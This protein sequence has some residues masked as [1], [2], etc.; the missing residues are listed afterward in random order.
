MT[1]VFP[2]WRIALDAAVAF[3]ASLVLLL[4]LRRQFKISLAEAAIMA[5]TAGLSVLIWRSFA[6]TPTLNNDPIPP[7]SPN[8]TLSPV[9]AYVALGMTAAFSRPRDEA[10]WSRA[11]VVLA[12]LV[13]VVNVVTV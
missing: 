5:G 11:R 13:F 9:I 6:N 2:F 1:G 8:D 10:R 7:I 3:V 4:A 12:L